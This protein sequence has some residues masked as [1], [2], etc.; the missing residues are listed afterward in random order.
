MTTTIQGGWKSYATEVMPLNA[1]DVQVQE[2]RRA[3]FAGAMWL[4][5]FITGPVTDLPDEEGELIM[6]A[7]HNE[8]D[9][10]MKDIKEGKA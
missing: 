9:A 3:F 4:F 6:T 1:S 5:L 7:I 8:I 2:T 10:Y